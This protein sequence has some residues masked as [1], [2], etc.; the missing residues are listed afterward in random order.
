MLL[1][2]LVVLLL[3]LAATWNLAQLSFTHTQLRATC[4]AAALA[5]AAQ[6]MDPSVLATSPGQASTYLG[7]RGAVYAYC[8]ANSINGQP[9]NVDL[10]LANDPQ[11]DIVVGCVQNPTRVHDPFYPSTGLGPVN[12]VQVAGYRNRTNGGVPLWLGGMAGL[13]FG[14]AGYLARASIDSRV[15]GFRPAPAGYVPLVPLASP[16]AAWQG[17][18]SSAGDGFTVNYTTGAVIAGPDGIPE[19]ELRGDLA[20]SVPSDSRATNKLVAL[21][22]GP[23]T[24]VADLQQQVLNGYGEADL[25]PLGGEFSLQ[26]QGNLL[27]PAQLALD[28]SLAQSLNAICGQIRVWPIGTLTCEGEATSY[29]VLGF[30]AGVMVDAFVDQTATPPQLVVVV[31][32]ALLPT[33]T[34]L[35]REESPANPWIAKLMLTH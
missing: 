19:I 20:A 29:D 23:S 15:Y 22:V 9:L 25:A 2:S 33:S 3:I 1:V 16:M 5:G 13:N 14:E 4:Q 24:S 10:N 11:G 32:P 12:T 17:G 18:T 21:L 7:V 35:V 6:L 30:A 34:A 8:Q 28:S 26:P 31:Q 27:L